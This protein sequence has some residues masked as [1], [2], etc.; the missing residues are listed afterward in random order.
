[1]Q[2]LQTFLLEAPNERCRGRCLANS[3]LHIFRSGRSIEF[4]DD[5]D[6][7]LIPPKASKRE[8]LL[9][10]CCHL[11]VPA[12]QRDAIAGTACSAPE[13]KKKRQRVYEVRGER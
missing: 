13:R 4:L 5:L 6:L 3:R 1:M 7:C 8:L 9:T 12:S 10:T 11:C 2:S